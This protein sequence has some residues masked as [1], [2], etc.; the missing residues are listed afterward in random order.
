VKRILV[1][2]VASVVIASPARAAID[3][4]PVTSEG[5]ITAWLYEDH[6]IPIVT[7]EASFTGG[8]V[9]DPEG[10]EGVTTLMTGLLGEGAGDMDTTAF[11]E[12]RE[13]QAARFSFDAYRD[14]VNVS[15]EMLA[16]NR[17][18][19]IDLL[20]LALAEPRFDASAVERVRAQL[21]SRI[22]S[23]LTDPNAIAGHAFYAHMFP[24]HPY[25]RP[26]D[27]TVESV[28]ALDA[29]DLRAAHRA[30]L[31]QDRLHVAVV[32]A[33]TPE[34]LGPVLDRLFGDLPAE[35]P[36]LPPVADAEATGE[37][38]IVE[39]GIPQSVVMFG[40]EG[41]PR[42]DPDFVPAFVMDHI[43]GGGGFGSRL[44]EELREQRG[45]TYGIYTALVP[46]DFGWLYFGRFSSAN[47]R[48]A[49]AIALVRAEWERMAEEGVTEAELEAAK[50]YLTGA[51]PLRFSSNADI[52]NQLLGIQ[53]AGLGID[54]VNVRNDLV[55][56][57]TVD[58]VARV[59]ERILRPENLA[60]V[61]VGQPEKLDVT[62]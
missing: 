4:T 39:L 25:S 11:A 2:F 24:G 18:A 26:V 38:E 23:D 62:N 27:G 13:A 57:V 1:A 16:E 61:V 32:G 30:A 44:T 7:L 59:A 8:A 19:S 20:R 43:L 51:Y 37:L 53:T 60:T 49:E 17:D 52:A 21:L 6:T 15:A 40:H 50:R 42:D 5:G 48:V 58:D 10:K 14:S 47:D 36:P 9:L 12:A 41:I 35:G 56:A 29:S 46:G 31:T 55:E 33:I 34:E 22:R 28:S 54:Y 3:I 45:L